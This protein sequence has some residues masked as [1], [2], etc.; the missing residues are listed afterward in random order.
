MDSI[1]MY[2]TFILLIIILVVVVYHVYYRLN[3]R[4]ITRQLYELLSIPD[5][6]QFLTIEA[7]QRDAIN[8]A[9]ALNKL[10]KSTRKSRIEI[11]TLNRAFRQ[12]ITNISHDLRTPLT[13]ASGYIQMLQAGVTEEESKQYLKII[14]ERQNMVQMLL[15]QLFEYVRIQSGEILYEHVPVDAKR[16]FVD[17]LT[18]YY[19]DFNRK[20]QEPQVNL[21]DYPCIVLGDTQGLKRIFS[22]ILF[23]AL[24][25]GAGGYCFEIRDTECYS[26]IF[27]NNSE[28]MTGDDLDNIFERSYTLDNPRNRKTTGL[29]LAIA[30]EITRKLGGDIEAFYNNGRFT[31][32]ITLPKA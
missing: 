27:S 30:K 17:T 29:G 12:S 13:T 4:S 6:N 16:I 31:I 19:D 15:N 25:H 28:P 7:P 18:T 10:I 32:S 21:P 1:W 24:T 22:N 5:T 8:L 9:K 23:N 20:A 26:F 11:D 2:M 14:L 3:I